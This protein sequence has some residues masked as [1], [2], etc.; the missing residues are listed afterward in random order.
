MTNLAEALSAGECSP[1]P[2][3]HSSTRPSTRRYISGK[4]DYLAQL[5]RIGGHVRGREGMIEDDRWCPDVVTP[6]LLGHEGT[7]GG[8]RPPAQRPPEPLRHW[9]GPLLDRRRPEPARRGRR[10]DP[11]GSA[12]MRSRGP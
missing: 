5:R 8:G 1:P 4:D 2:H 9:L 6:G 3:A 11:P 10:H 7:P 12:P